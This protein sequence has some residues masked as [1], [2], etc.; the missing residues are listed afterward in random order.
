[1]LDCVTFCNEAKEGAD[2]G[3]GICR[4]VH[5][6]LSSLAN[7]SALSRTECL[8]VNDAFLA[9]LDGASQRKHMLVTRWEC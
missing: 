4:E 3:E 9:R 7:D 1:M 2:A 6:Q 8:L 5:D